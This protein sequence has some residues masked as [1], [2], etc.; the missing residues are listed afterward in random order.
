MMQDMA[1]KGLAAKEAEKIQHTEYMQW[2]VDTTR[3]KKCAQCSFAR[4]I[5]GQRAWRVRKQ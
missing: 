4:A 1:A 2:C 5:V 3:T